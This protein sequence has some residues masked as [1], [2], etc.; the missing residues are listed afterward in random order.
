MAN[1][2]P[3]NGRNQYYKYF[4]FHMS[5]AVCLFVFL[6]F[7]RTHSQQGSLFTCLFVFPLF[8][9]FFACLFFFFL[10]GSILLSL[11]QCREN[12]TSGVRVPG[13]FRAK[14][15]FNLI[16]MS[17][18][19]VAIRLDDNVPETELQG[20]CD[21]NPSTTEK[22][23]KGEIRLFRQDT[24]EATEA[25]RNKAKWLI[26]VI[27]I[28]ETVTCRN[29]LNYRKL[30]PKSIIRVVRIV[31]KTRNQHCLL[32]RVADTKAARNLIESCNGE[33]FDPHRPEI[34]HAI[35]LYGVYLLSSNIE[36]GPST[37]VPRATINLD[38]Q[39]APTSQVYNLGTFTFDEISP[40]PHGDSEL[41]TC[42]T[43]LERLDTS[44]SGIVPRTTLTTMGRWED[45]ACPVC[46]LI[47]SRTNDPNVSAP[48]T[49]T[50]NTPEQRELPDTE[51]SNTHYST[52]SAF[53]VCEKCNKQN[54]VSQTLWVCLICAH[55]GCGRYGARHAVSHFEETFHRYSMDLQNLCIW[56]YKGDGFIHRI[57]GHIE[58]SR[59]DYSA[60]GAEFR[61]PLS[62]ENIDE[63]EAMS[64]TRIKLQ[65]VSLYYDNLLADQLKQQKEYFDA[66][67][68]SLECAHVEQ[69]DGLRHSNQELT[70][71]VFYT[72]YARFYHTCIRLNFSVCA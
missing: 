65:S 19:E 55:V 61:R 11:F 51:K 24:R 18:F 57:G 31:D 43:C 62:P 8:F 38:L 37:K 34:C 35:P 12:F 10:V 13:G 54:E 22:K 29:W 41:P 14:N 49:P 58:D 70:E 39:N 26:C 59:M 17:T 15:P 3:K 44:A 21:P 68:T 33:R 52:T 9:F 7:S 40:L 36:F 50:E 1:A 45:L 6:S 5:V 67:M 60:S 56:D 63:T 27:A 64:L 20:L 71:Q 23:L 47:R 42:P 2:E 32:L 16:F 46:S 4:L 69:L 30:D 28:P 72:A 25:Q 48:S 53:T 66:R